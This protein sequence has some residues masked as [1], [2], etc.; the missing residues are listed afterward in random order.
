MSIKVSFN[1]KSIKDVENRIKQSFEKVIANPEM[2]NDIGE[3]IVK[4]IK[5]QTRR[6]LSIP[7]NGPLKALSTN[8]HPFL[9]SIYGRLDFQ[10]AKPAGEK[11]SQINAAKRKNERLQALRETHAKDGYSWVDIRGYISNSTTTHETFKANRSNLTLTGQL[12]DSLKHRVFGAG[13]LLLEFTGVHKP[14][15]IRT[16]KGQR[17]VGEA[18]SNEE[19]A[20]HV[21]QIRPFVGVRDAIKKRIK[22]IVLSYLRR[23]SRVLKLF[24]E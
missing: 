7:N 20:E 10:R 12:L 19:L 17:Q 8:R 18:I 24:E 22:I 9:Y 11:K 4:D 2:M 16:A 5:Y 3:T 15:K 6:G 13:K 21:Q 14:Y 23:S 1:E